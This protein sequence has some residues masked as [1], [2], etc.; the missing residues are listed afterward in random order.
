MGKGRKRHRRTNSGVEN[1][2][3]RLP[4]KQE[5]V[6]SSPTTATIPEPH[7]ATDL[8]PIPPQ[9]VAAMW[10]LAEDLLAPELP[11]TDWT[12]EGLR[13]MCLM[14][15]A[16]L[17]MIVNESDEAV[18]AMVTL[19]TPKQRLLVAICSG[20][21]LWKYL[22]ARHQLYALAKDHGL[23]EVTFYGRPALAKLMPECKR[24]GV[25]LRKEL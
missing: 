25:I 17:W 8:V 19:E 14:G 23:K 16:Q 10:P 15:E 1:G 2:T 11:Q 12:P 13:H 22:D 9:E 20:P 3:S 7:E 6:G 18:A 21:N 4:H 5:I 24:A